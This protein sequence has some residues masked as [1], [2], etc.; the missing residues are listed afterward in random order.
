MT[1]KQMLN[2]SSSVSCRLEGF[3]VAMAACQMM[4]SHGVAAFSRMLTIIYAS[5]HIFRS[6]ICLWSCIGFGWLFSIV[7]ALPYLFLDG[8]T[9]STST[10]RTFL[11]YYTLFSVLLLPAMIVGFCNGRVFLF[12]RKSTRQVHA[13]GS[14]G[15]VSHERDVRL[16]EIM[17]VTFTIFFA[18]W[19][20]VLLTQT[21]GNSNSLPTVIGACLQVLPSSTVFFD[22]A[23]LIYTN[24]PVRRFL[25]QLIVR[26]PR[27]ALVN[28]TL[29]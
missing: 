27:N 21:F 24:Q 19:T 18:G 23:C 11:S 9:C 15:K 4:Y 6:N 1:V 13:Q 20:P 28:N 3:L 10:T 22:V 7:I 8:F 29:R 2:A 26:H 5:K 14:S 12:V 17:I 16:L 25:K